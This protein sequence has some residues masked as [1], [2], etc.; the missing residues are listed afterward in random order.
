MPTRSLPL[1]RDIYLVYIVS[2]RPEQCWLKSFSHFFY[3]SS[4]IDLV[5]QFSN[6]RSKTATRT[7]LL[8]IKFAIV[9]QIAFFITTTACL[10]DLR[11]FGDSSSEPA[12]RVLLLESSIEFFPP[13]LPLGLIIYI[14]VSQ[15]VNLLHEHCC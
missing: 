3:Y 14:S 15:V 2:L 4:H 5:R 8:I 12:I 1:I 6:S 10:I 9:T 13:G 11:P 7:L